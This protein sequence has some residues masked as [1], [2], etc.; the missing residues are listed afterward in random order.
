V[1]AKVEQA[2]PGQS[3]GLVALAIQAALGRPRREPLTL[4]HAPAA[5]FRP[6]QPLEIELAAGRSFA[7]VRMYYRHVTHEQRYQTA[8]MEALGSRYRATIPAAY[9]ASPYP[10]QYYF[11]LKEN[12]ATAWQYPGFSAGLANQPYF[13]VRQAG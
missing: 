12:P 5:H 9:T 10:L 8:D 13:V 7:F 1:A 3:E 11:E 4:R 2:K 6:G